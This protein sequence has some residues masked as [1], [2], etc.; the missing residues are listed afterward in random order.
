M[1]GAA[2]TT[3]FMVEILRVYALVLVSVVSLEIL[4][5]GP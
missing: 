3:A 4:K 2:F 5:R 1:C